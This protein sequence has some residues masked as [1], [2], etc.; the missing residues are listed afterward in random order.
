MIK[1][2]TLL[3]LGAGAS[4]P[5]GFPPGA[6]LVREVCKILHRVPGGDAQQSPKLRW[7]ADALSISVPGRGF[8]SIE[9]FRQ[10]LIDSLT[11]SVDAF[12]EYNQAFIRIG[13]CAIATALLTKEY[14][15]QHEKL[16]SGKPIWYQLLFSALNAPFD[17]FQNNELSIVTFNYDRSLEYHLHRALKGFYHGKSDKECADKLNAIPIIHVHG[18]LGKLQWQENDPAPFIRYGSDITPEKVHLAAESIKIIHED[19]LETD[20][21]K[22]AHRIIREAQRIYTLGF[23]YAEQNLKRL[24][25]ASLRRREDFRVWGT[26]MGLSRAAIQRVSKLNFKNLNREVARPDKLADMSIY[27]FLHNYVDLTG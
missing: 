16:M 23:G 19:V 7:I 14:P 5:V 4:V 2:K 17:D 8:D 24:K 26:G 21:F 1:T 6:E 22:E 12:L 11:P 27:D 10:A 25:L 20:E 13:K 15:R 3:I 18:K 9:K